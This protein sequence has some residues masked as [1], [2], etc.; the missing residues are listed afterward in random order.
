[1]KIKFLMIGLFSL[2]S[3]TTAF[4]QKGALRDAQDAFDKYTIEATQKILAAKATS[5]LNE[6]KTAIDKAASNAK[7]ATM[8]QT[9]ALQGAIYAAMAVR[10][11]VPTTAAP[12]LTT[13]Q[14][15]I[16][17]AKDADTKGEYKK[18][19]DKA[20]S[21]IALYY[22]N[23]GVKQYQGKKYEQAYQ[24]FSNWNTYFPDTTAVYYA[25]LSAGLAGNNNPKFYGYAI[26]AYNKL[27][28]TNFSENQKIYNYLS[29]LY[30]ITK[31]TT[32]AL[33]TINA[34][35]AKY[36][37]N[38]TLREVQVG[39]ALQAGKQAEIIGQIDAAIASDPKNKV[40]YYYKGVTYSRLGEEVES[41]ATKTKDNATKT[42]LQKESL[43]DYAKAVDAYK[44][45]VEIDPNYFE[46]IVNLG[47]ALM[48][49]GID[50]FN[51]A[52]NLPANATQ[53]QYNDLRLKADAQFDI[54]KPYL[55]KA[56]DLNP[57]SP[58]ALGNL[59]NYYRGK[60]DPANKAANQAKADEL[61]KE[62][63]ALPSGK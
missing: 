17:K 42:N 35:V 2:V 55:Q 21:D 7:T 59:R 24:S 15:A 58:D 57:K 5:D 3:A 38:S 63:D 16:K 53:K 61:K 11:T 60:Y 46:A 23:E 34:G 9:Y 30:L 25:A 44:K 54:A 39:M 41:K 13:A 20:G 14:D 40:L 50:M 56:V 33:K 28:A 37:N 29:T 4:A 51:Q 31:D 12:L 26:T 10:D 48:K 49:P 1:M 43:D 47:E 36:P 52:N 6:A 19:I 18:I 32:N 45:A 22:Q 27:L 8:A 62:I